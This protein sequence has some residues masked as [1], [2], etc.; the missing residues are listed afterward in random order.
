MIELNNISKSYIDGNSQNIV[1]KSF[2]LRI[3]N[4]DFFTI[5]GPSG[6]GKST[7]LNIIALLTTPTEGQVIYDDYVVDFTN[8]KKVEK[9]RRERIGLVFQNANLISCLN[10][11]DNIMLAAVSNTKASREYAMY[12]LDRLGIRDKYKSNI[13]T[14]SGG[15]A[16]RVS[17]VRALINKPQLLLCDEPTG[18]LDDKNSKLVMELLIE[19]YEEVKC[20]LLIITHDKGIGNFG[21]EQIIL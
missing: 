12:L 15:E 2:D 14:L 6:S 9:L 19:I 3:G 16:Q 1:L 4:N 21:K 10:V 20:S 18:A 8:E 11:I 17:I 5:M 7:L 13:K